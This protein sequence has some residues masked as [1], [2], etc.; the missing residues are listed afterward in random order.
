MRKDKVIKLDVRELEPPMP[1]VE[2]LKALENLEE[3]QVLEV[4]GLKPFKHLLP[5]LKEAGYKYTLEEVKEGYRL[6]IWL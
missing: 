3:G 4:L 5:K 1:M 2:I 6:R